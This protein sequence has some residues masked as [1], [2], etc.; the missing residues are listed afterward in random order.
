MPGINLLL[1]VYTLTGSMHTN[2]LLFDAISG[3]FMFSENMASKVLESSNVIFSKSH[4]K[5]LSRQLHERNS[6]AMALKIENLLARL[7]GSGKKGAPK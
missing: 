7:S 1:P 5:S 4:I 2:A 3:R 6:V